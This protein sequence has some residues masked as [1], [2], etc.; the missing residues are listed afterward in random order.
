MALLIYLI[1]HGQTEWALS[2]R[3]TGWTDVALTTKGE[4]EA[5]AVGERLR[6]ISFD[7]VL[8]SPLQRARRTAALAGHADAEPM[9]DLMECNYG[10]YEGWTSKEILAKNPRWDLFHD[11]C[12]GG[13]SPAELTT[14][15][16]RVADLLRGLNGRI[17]VFAHGHILRVVA[18][19]WAKLA[20]ESA[21]ALTLRT[22]SIS[23]LGFDRDHPETPVI[24]LWNSGASLPE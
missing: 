2:G 3:H 13:E 21:R 19:R 14:R 15:A 4:D 12:P 23:V 8:T 7:R 20:M 9:P 24:R 10:N 18:V 1:R 5:R 11:G 6:S 17:L 16:D 22:G